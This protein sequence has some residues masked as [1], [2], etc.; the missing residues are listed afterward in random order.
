MLSIRKYFR[1]FAD[2]PAIYSLLYSARFACYSKG[3]ETTI[4]PALCTLRFSVKVS[5]YRRPTGVRPL[6]KILISSIIEFMP[7][8]LSKSVVGIPST[9]TLY[10][11]KVCKR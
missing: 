4:K 11:L 9:T 8:G 10:Q 7:S 1:T 6:L 5:Q 2:I 3:K